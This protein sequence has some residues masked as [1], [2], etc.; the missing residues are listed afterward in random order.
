MAVMLRGV[1]PGFRDP[2][3]DSLDLVTERTGAEE[4]AIG[5]ANQVAHAVGMGQSL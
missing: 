3:A 5:P 4:G 2:V 1:K